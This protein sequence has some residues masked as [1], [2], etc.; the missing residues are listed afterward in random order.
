MLSSSHLNIRQARIIG[1]S[2]R[3]PHTGDRRPETAK[4]EGGFGW[5]F[6]GCHLTRGHA[7]AVGQ[8]RMTMIAVSSEW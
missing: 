5:G 8:A 3:D 1:V 6:R 2:R 4:D 7:E